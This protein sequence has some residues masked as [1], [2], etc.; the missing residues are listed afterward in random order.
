MYKILKIGGKE[1]K[2]EYSIEASLYEDCT[3]SV[4][5]TLVSTNGGVGG[6][7]LKEV[8]SGMA[9]LPNSTLTI[10]YA[11]LIQNHG[12]HPDGDGTVP[13]FETAKKLAVQYLFE[14]KDDENGNF[15]ALFEMCLVQMEEDGFFKL[16]GLEKFLDDI[17]RT[18][19]PKRAP[20]KPA[21]HQR[22][23]TAK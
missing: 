19:K 6:K 5:N 17:N 15:Y 13:D 18:S 23:T 14:H 11:G 4:M 22:K 7:S 1:Y 20:K 8:I 10:F 16:T 3:S 12:T 21:D 9:N 2:L